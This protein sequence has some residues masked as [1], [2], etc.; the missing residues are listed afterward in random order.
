MRREHISGLNMKNLGFGSDV[1]YDNT[2]LR[3]R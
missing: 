3:V 2:F 1:D